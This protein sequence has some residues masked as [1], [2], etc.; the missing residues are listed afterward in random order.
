MSYKKNSGLSKIDKSVTISDSSLVVTVGLT[1]SKLF[2]FSLKRAN[3]MFVE[4]KSFLNALYDIKSIESA[5]QL[6]VM[7]I[8]E[9][10]NVVAFE[11]KPEEPKSTFVSLGIYFIPQEKVVDFSKYLSEGKDPDKIGYFWVWVLEQGTPFY[12]YVYEE[13]WFDIGWMQALEE[14]RRDFEG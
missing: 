6:G 14:A 13:K 1:Y 7:S 9:D 11:E 3:D 5:K 4:K 12:G 10:G 8:D 2:N